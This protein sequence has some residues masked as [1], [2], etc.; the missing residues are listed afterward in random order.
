MKPS[1]FAARVLL[2]CATLCGFSWAADAKLGQTLSGVC[3]TCHG[4]QGLSVLPNAPNLAGQPA[5]YLEE[6]LKH[7]RNGK[8][9]H[10]VMGVIAK[11]LSDSDIENLA[12]WYANIKIQVLP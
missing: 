12:A 2:V 8:R 4:A 11:P 10:E 6:Q 1:T 9:S 5:I 7:Y 3:S